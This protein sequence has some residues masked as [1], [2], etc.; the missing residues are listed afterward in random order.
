MGSLAGVWTD[1]PDDRDPAA[2]REAFRQVFGHG[3]DEV[4]VGGYP[5][6]LCAFW[7][8]YLGLT[9]VRPHAGP[10]VAELKRKNAGTRVFDIVLG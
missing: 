1:V 6:S 2:I 3:W 5:P 4:L 10:A 9:G 8:G 7:D